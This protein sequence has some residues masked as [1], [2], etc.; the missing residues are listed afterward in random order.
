MLL[1]YSLHFFFN[2]SFDF[3]NLVGDDLELFLVARAVA[4]ESGASWTFLVLEFFFRFFFLLL[5]LQLHEVVQ[6]FH[7]KAV[8]AV[9]QLDEAWVRVILVPEEDFEAFV[10]RVAL[11]AE[12]GAFFSAKPET[13]MPT[14]ELL[15]TR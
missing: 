8:F 7:H 6:I 12:L 11:S 13:I 4:D 3:V 2:F 15:G 14:C 9:E 5:L 10:I 1:D